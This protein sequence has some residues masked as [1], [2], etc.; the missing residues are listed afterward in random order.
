MIPSRFSSGI[1]FEMKTNRTIPI[2]GVSAWGEAEQ[3]MLVDK[4][5]KFKVAHTGVMTYNINEDGSQRER[6]VVQLEQLDD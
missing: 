5:I 2:G 1:I 6:Y 4:D 3:E